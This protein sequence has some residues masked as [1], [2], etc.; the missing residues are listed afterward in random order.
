MGAPVF[1]VR[2]GEPNSG[3]RAPGILGALHS[4][5]SDM[6][7]IHRISHLAFKFNIK[8]INHKKTLISLN[9]QELSRKIMII[10]HLLN[11]KVLI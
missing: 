6:D 2:F 9:A 3:Q 1:C 10:V 4:T 11:D 7:R 8:H 5:W